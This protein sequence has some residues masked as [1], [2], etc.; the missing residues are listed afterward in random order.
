[1]PGHQRAGR[2]LLLDRADGG[3]RG[4]QR[5]HAVLR[6]HPPERAGVR[7]ADR[8]ALVEHGGAPGQQRGV[9][10][11]GVADHPAD[12]ARGPPHLARLDAEDVAHRPGQRHRVAAVVA[13]DPLG[14]A[15]GAGGVEDVERVGRLH[16]HA[17]GAGRGVGV[18][19]RGPVHV[20]LPHRGDGLLALQDDAVLGHVAGPLDRRVEHRLV[21]HHPGRLDAAGRRDDRPWAGRP[22]SG[23]PARPARS[24]RTRPSAPRRCGRRPASPRPPRAPSACRSRPGRPCRRRAP[25]AHRRSGR[26]A[27]AAGRRSGSARCR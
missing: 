25:A 11:V 21:L 23:R 12:V 22:R 15:R 6:D 27:P 5:G 14:T 16:G 7:G 2:V 24:R 3:R 8:L 9:D 10:D 1:M 26:P 4:E 17:A 19:D 13:H 20:A 18:H